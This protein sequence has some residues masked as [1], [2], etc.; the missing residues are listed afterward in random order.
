M[1]EKINMEIT[2]THI[3]TLQSI[4]SRHANY[5]LNC[6]AWCVTVITAMIIFFYEERQTIN[7]FIFLLPIIV[8]YLLDCFYLG[9]ERLFKQNYNDFIKKLQTDSK[10]EKDI[11]ISTK[12]K[13]KFIFFL[14][15][16]VSF[17]TTPIYLVM[18]I[19]IFFIYKGV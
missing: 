15:G 18:C 1:N 9:L 7:S 4:I 17:S 5:S 13:N 11:K 14:K 10:I 2:Q 12:G 6:K 16:F 19:F 8:F 3:N